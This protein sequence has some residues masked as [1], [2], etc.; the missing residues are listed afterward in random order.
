MSPRRHQRPS[1]G[2]TSTHHRPVASGEGAQLRWTAR[3]V[4]REASHHH[5][6]AGDIPRAEGDPGPAGGLTATQ[7]P[8]RPARRTGT[9]RRPNAGQNAGT[10]GN[11]TAG[12]HEGGHG[13]QVTSQELQ[14]HYRTELAKMIEPGSPEKQVNPKSTRWMIRLAETAEGGAFTPGDGTQTWIWSDLHLHHRNIT[15]R[16]RRRRPRCRGCRW[17]RRTSSDA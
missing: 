15:G 1:G 2:P 8:P 12:S 10:D 5:Q 6:L 11:G 16:R 4:G 9:L 7:A 13:N 17:R 3:A 14:A